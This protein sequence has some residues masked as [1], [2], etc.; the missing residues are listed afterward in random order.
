MNFIE[1]Y[2]ERFRDDYGRFIEGIP[3]KSRHHERDKSEVTIQFSKLFRDKGHIGVIDPECLSYFAV[4]LFLTILVDEVVYTHYKHHYDKFRQLTMYPKF[5]G[6]CP[7]ACHYHLH[8]TSIFRGLNSYFDRNRLMEE[9]QVEFRDAFLEAIPGMKK[10]CDDFIEKHMPEMN[11]E[12]FWKR[13]S[14]EFPYSSC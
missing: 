5:I 14:S 2:R 13:C 1:Y 4:S 10:E 7:G 8:P 12:D 6:D 9:K 11:K 3:E